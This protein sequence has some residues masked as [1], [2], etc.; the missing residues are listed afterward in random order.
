[1]K[2][3]LL[4]VAIIFMAA[5]S[6]RAQFSLGAK[7]GVNF[8]KISTDNV[9]ESTVAGYQAGL[10]ARF[11]SS[12]YLQPELYVASSGGK[13][14]FNNNGGTVTTN[15][16]VRFTSLNVP[17]LIGKG[18]GGDNLNIRVMAGPVYSYLMDKNQNFGDNVSGA[19][20]DFGN[21]KK[22]TLGYQV[23]GGIDVGH[24]TADL[25]YEG[26]LTKI[27]ENYGQRQNIWALSVGFKFF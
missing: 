11:G 18:F 1:M 25:R 26:G 21:Y 23:G 16:K 14:D 5:I 3:C 15:G 7:A 27:N 13:F 9:S 4:S 2:K 10:F 19:D 24:I 20:N 12:L 17:L 8:S 22:S 6:A